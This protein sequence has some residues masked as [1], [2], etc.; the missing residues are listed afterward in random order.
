MQKATKIRIYALYKPGTCIPFYVGKS[1]NPSG[2]YCRWSKEVNCYV[3][4]LET[5]YGKVIR[6]KVLCTVNVENSITY[7]RQWV[8]FYKRQ[9]YK[10]LNKNNGGG[11]PV[12]HSEAT[13]RKIRSKRKLQIIH[14]SEATKIK[15]GLAHKG[16]P[17]KGYFS[18]SDVDKRR[19]NLKISR[20][21]KGVPKSKEH[22]RKI[23]D[24]LRGRRLPPERIKL[25]C[26]MW[27]DPVYR[28]KMLKARGIR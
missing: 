20:K 21:L 13:I 25:M 24:A 10:L 14:H 7:E 1:L 5:K 23:G 6:P 3:K 12:A 27:K 8:T 26:K 4:H 9:G 19:R 11:G 18:L 16:I 2:R 17:K 22:G 28:S 15:I